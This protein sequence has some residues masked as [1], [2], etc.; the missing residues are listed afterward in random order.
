MIKILTGDNYNTKKLNNIIS[1]I[2][3]FISISRFLLFMPKFNFPSTTSFNAYSALSIKPG[4]SGIRFIISA[5][6]FKAVS[7]VD[8]GLLSFLTNLPKQV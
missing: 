5:D 6:V 3:E 4:K 7:I 8:L 1:K 2:F